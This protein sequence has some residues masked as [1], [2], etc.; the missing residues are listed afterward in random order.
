MD[1][2]ILDV[3]GK[4]FKTY[5]S[6][7]TKYPETMLGKMFSDDSKFKVDVI[8]FFDRSSK[9]FDAI[10]NFYRIGILVKPP[11]VSRYIWQEEIKFWGLPEGISKSDEEDRNVS[12]LAR[13]INDS[14]VPILNGQTLKFDEMIRHL[15]SIKHY[16]R[17][18]A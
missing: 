2:I 1:T 12:R 9:L 8:P 17:C 6:T 14:L 10:L 15:D 5:R 11:Q 7:L 18:H 16:S 4:R 13:K 3:G